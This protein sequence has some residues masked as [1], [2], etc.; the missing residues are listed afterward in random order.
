MNFC[1]LTQPYD[2]NS[3]TAPLLRKSGRL[4][5]LGLPLL[6]G[7]CMT[8][9]LLLARFVV[10]HVVNVRS[11]VKNASSNLSADDDKAKGMGA[12]GHVERQAFRK[13]LQSGVCELRGVPAESLI[14]AM[15]AWQCVGKLE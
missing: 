14:I 10:R 8:S 12:D 9:P 13:H 1:P 3:T 11:L 2:P 6:T 4:E 7:A 5:R 15:A